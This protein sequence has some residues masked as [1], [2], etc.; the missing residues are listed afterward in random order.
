MQKCQGLQM[1]NYFMCLKYLHL[2]PSSNVYFFP[3]CLKA[4]EPRHSVGELTAVLFPEKAIFAFSLFLFFIFYFFAPEKF[5]FA[6]YTLAVSKDS[7]TR[8]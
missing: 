5:S 7:E 3:W 2:P 6:L 1:S 4:L 8:T